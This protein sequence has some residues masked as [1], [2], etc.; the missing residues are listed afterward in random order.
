MK[1][2]GI[3]PNVVIYNSVINGL[4]QQG[5]LNEAFNSCWC[6]VYGRFPG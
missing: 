4:C 3:Y 6:F 1:K 2:K 5:C